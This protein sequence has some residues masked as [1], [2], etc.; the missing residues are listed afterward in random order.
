MEAAE[1]AHDSMPAEKRVEPP[2]PSGASKENQLPK[3][4]NVRK[5]TKT[6]CLSTCLP[7]LLVFSSPLFI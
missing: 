2:S 3:K 5:R 4:A 7:T 6:G 1:D